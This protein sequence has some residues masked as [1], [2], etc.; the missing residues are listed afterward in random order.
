MDGGT[1]A[2]M[3]ER[4]VGVE[5]F[6]VAVPQATLD[7]LAE[8]LPRTRWPDALDEAGW[9]DGTSPAFLRELVDWWQTRFDWRSQEAVI[10]RFAQFRAT[11]DGVGLHYVHERGKG[12][13][14]LP[15]VLTHGWPSTFY[16][17]LP[18]VPLL[19]DPAAHGGDAPTP[20]TS[21]SPRC[22]ATASATPCRVG[23]APTGC[24]SSGCGS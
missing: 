19:T 23:A 17:L 4:V 11:V 12:P 8:R 2:T 5:R 14:P 15:L 13:A 20:S 16:E 22:L 6:T 18:L 9:E 7:D 3:R 10:N 24:L 21:W 1:A